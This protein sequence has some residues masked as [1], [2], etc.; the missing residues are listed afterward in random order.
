LAKPAAREA[1]ARSSVST[2]QEKPT[3]IPVA[4]ARATPNQTVN[5]AQ[6]PDPE[7]QTPTPSPQPPA[8]NPQSPFAP[9]PDAVGWAILRVVQNQ[10][11]ELPRSGVVHFLRGTTDLGTRSSS[12][13]TALPGFRFLAQYPHQ[14]LLHAVDL[15]IEKKLLVV[16]ATEHLHL[17]L[18]QRGK[19]ALESCARQW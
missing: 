4:G 16:E 2:P 5:P 18:T 10:D 11:G 13:R 19:A 12:W 9:L 17:W 6:T 15:L 1:T 8:P 14:D 7:L 3:V